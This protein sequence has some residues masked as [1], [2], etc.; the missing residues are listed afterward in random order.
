MPIDYISF[1]SEDYPEPLRAIPDPPRGLYIIGDKALL[2]QRQ[3]AM[4][5][6]RKCTQAALALS[7]QWAAELASYD[8]V[9][10]SGMALG[11]DAA[12]HA[13][14]LST[15]KTLAVMGCGLNYVY[16]K[17]NATLIK[18]M[19]AKGGAIV[20]EY[21]PDTAAR[22]QYFPQRNRIISGLS[23]GVVV[24]EA[25]ERSGTLITAR[26]ASEQGRDVFAVPGHIANP[27]TAGCHRL[28]Q[29]GAKLV[30]SVRDIVEDYPWISLLSQSPT[31]PSLSANERS[32]LGALGTYTVSV[33][34]LVTKSGLAFVEVCSILLQLECQGIVR[35]VSGGYQ[36]TGIG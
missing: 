24:I 32:I 11:I 1:D 3:I 21:P 20:S 34:E 31:P 19:I 14:A 5:G 4:V 10:T 8:I 26:L 9:V 30:T 25:A 36:K 28:I 18:T 23:V 6:S 33:D 16:P 12:A 17:Q 13:G 27:N 29:Q 7:K 2:K 35:K 15:G 22:T